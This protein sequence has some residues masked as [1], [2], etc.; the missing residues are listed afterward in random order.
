M[1]KE[2]ED[3]NW[4]PEALRS[5]QLQVVGNISVWTKL[6]QPL[7]SILQQMIV[8][9]KITALQDTCSG[10]GMPAVYLQ[11][12]LTA[13][14]PMLLTDKYP[15]PGF[16]NKPAVIYALGAV[17]V[18]E[19]QP[20]ENTV[21]TMYNAFHHFPAAEQKALIKKMAV[22]KTCFLIGEILTPGFFNLVKI[23]LTTTLL[24]L[25]VAPFVKP[26]SLPRLFFTY[27]I[28]VNLFT[29]TYDGII[30]VVRSKTAAAYNDLLQD[31]SNPSYK[32][33]ISTIKNWKGNL[34][35]IKG[36]PV[37]T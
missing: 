9:N 15:V 28:P 1:I 24:Q 20:Q 16:K 22:Q 35:Y 34:V 12:Q 5:W 27:I 4:F 36:E 18:L 23:L 30:S 37:N 32:I 7:A 8:K 21:Y 6:Y 29:V 13:N 10:S 25:L 17:D 3:Y 33:T 2:L 26:F 19:I 31:I 11:Q 14:I